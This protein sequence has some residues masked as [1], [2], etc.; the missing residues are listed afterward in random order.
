MEDFILAPNMIFEVL[1]IS[2]ARTGEFLG[3]AEG[4]LIGSFGLDR[5]IT[6]TAGDGNDVA[7]YS[8]ASV[9]GDFDNDGDVD[10]HDFITWQRN[11]NVGTLA[12]WQ[13]NYV[14][15]STS[16]PVPEPT[17][18]MLLLASLATVATRVISIRC[19]MSCYVNSTET[20]SSH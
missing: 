1:N 16:S 19:P 20:F 9:A 18:A 12:Q 14:P 8:S 6:Y 7:L 10:G 13:N 5:F 4:A 2:G 17:T 3:L 15:A 11:P